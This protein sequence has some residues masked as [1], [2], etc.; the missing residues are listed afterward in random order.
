MQ[1]FL[2]RQKVT[3]I[4]ASGE[5]TSDM[6]RVWSPTQMPQ[7]SFLFLRSFGRESC[8]AVPLTRSALEVVS[9]KSSRVIGSTAKCM[10]MESA[11]PYHDGYTW[12]A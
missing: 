10:A 11:L 4:R 7:P 9:S 8:Q 12:T 2:P 1:R 3:S 5:M 6:E